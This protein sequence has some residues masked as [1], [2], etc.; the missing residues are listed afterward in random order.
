MRVCFGYSKPMDDVDFKSVDIQGNPNIMDDVF[1]LKNI[2][3]NSCD[4]IIS[5]HVLEHGNYD[6]TASQR[7]DQLVEVLKL[8]YSKLKGGGTLYLAVPNF[9][10]VVSCYMEYRN[11]FWNHTTDMVGPLFGGGS[12]L[13]D[14]HRMFF[15]K[16]L[17]IDIMSAA[18]FVDLSEMPIGSPEFLPLFNSS[19]SDYRG[20][21]MKGVKK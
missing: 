18:G 1:V 10:F 19:S 13:Y 17:L 12:N 11:I 14:F 21:N 9:D 15:N 2:K 8:W 3:D 4:I 16:P 7:R 20:I 5:S 6:G